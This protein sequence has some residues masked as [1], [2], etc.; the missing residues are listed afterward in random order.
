[1][2]R[3][4]FWLLTIVRKPF[5]LLA[6]DL[7]M[8]DMPSPNQLSS[9]HV[10]ARAVELGFDLCGIAGVAGVDELARLPEWL[11]R[12]FGGRMTYLNRTARVRAD[13]RGW[14]P[15]ARAIVAVANIYNTDHPH[16]VEMADPSQ[17]RVARYA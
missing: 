8:L 15:S 13:I 7:R 9:A 11:G 12:G 16:H 14:L 5:L 6:S 10:K 2:R 17:A 1:V 3:V 4:S